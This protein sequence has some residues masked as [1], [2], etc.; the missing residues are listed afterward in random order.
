MKE[1]AKSNMYE[2]NAESVLAAYGAFVQG[3]PEA[4]VLAVA[5]EPAAE[6]VR[7]AVE[8]SVQRLGF[9]QGACAWLT[10]EADGM[11]LGP[12][13]VGAIAEGLDPLAVAL[14]DAQA[15]ELFGRTYGCELA[16]D[17]ATR[18]KGRAV[19]AF[20]SFEAM[21]ADADQKQQAWALLKKLRAR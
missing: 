20:R 9:N 11:Q 10:L 19:A 21:L 13:E 5:S 16:L 3:T 18:V 7:A 12:Q 4:T 15:A 8:S 14:L 1:S 17:E 6:A 2:V